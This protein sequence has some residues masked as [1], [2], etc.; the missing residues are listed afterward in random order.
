M[1]K[2]NLGNINIYDQ[3]IPSYP[4]LVADV[5]NDGGMED[6]VEV[7]DITTL[8]NYFRYADHYKDY[9]KLIN[10]GATLVLLGNRKKFDDF[11]TFTIF[12]K[13][14]LEGK[15][16]Y[17][18]INPDYLE[19]DDE[20]VI[21]KVL[22][23]SRC[24]TRHTDTG[25]A[26][27]Q[28]VVYSE[29]KHRTY[30]IHFRLKDE[31]STD[32][33]YSLFN[34]ASIWLNEHRDTILRLVIPAREDEY[35]MTRDLSLG[36]QLQD[37]PEDDE[38]REINRLRLVSRGFDDYTT[39]GG[40]VSEGITND[41]VRL[42]LNEPITDEEFLTQLFYPELEND[43]LWSI[44]WNWSLIGLDYGAVKFDSDYKGFTIDTPFLAYFEDLCDEF[45]PLFEITNDEEYTQ[46]LYHTK[47]LITQ[48]ILLSG[49]TRIPNKE[50]HD[51]VIT[52]KATSEYQTFTASL[53]EQSETFVIENPL[54]E[55]AESQLIEIV[56]YNHNI[57]EEIDYDGGCKLSNFIESSHDN[58]SLYNAY[59]SVKEYEVP[60]TCMIAPRHIQEWI[61]CRTSRGSLKELFREYARTY[62]TG[63]RQNTLLIQL[64]EESEVGYEDTLSIENAFYFSGSYDGSENVYAY[65]IKILIDR[66]FS[67]ED[68]SDA[69]LPDSEELKKRTLKVVYENHQCKF[70]DAQEL[71]VS[72]GISQLINLIYYSLSPGTPQNLITSR[73]N[74]SIS[75]VQSLNRLIR[76]VSIENIVQKQNTLEITLV[77][78]YRLYDKEVTVNFNLYKSYGRSSDT[79]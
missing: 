45:C 32:G 14:Y 78:Y 24:F 58:D 6:P 33:N 62:P 48:G 72:L 21:S 50:G 38:T 51:I 75:A 16:N 28:T 42:I 27:I 19:M 67:F 71:V 59:E 56:R 64:E 25:K 18:T 68:N 49:R 47:G 41:I 9:V 60:V 15:V 79:P 54:R 65:L 22:S 74:G 77:I 5:V 26:L 3:K 46:M 17:T 63:G 20:D 13:G 12:N 29:D 1:S 61:K 53:F 34:A 2:F 70:D 43:P 40:M 39:K 30:R 11:A 31:Y 8:Y 23:D 37:F 73:L 57:Q 36:I 76:R 10:A 69:I 7:A 55:M 35:S 4:F 44:Y 66:E 52:Y